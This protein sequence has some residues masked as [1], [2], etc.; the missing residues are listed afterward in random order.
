MAQVV[1]SSAGHCL[2]RKETKHLRER[3]RHS[4]FNSTLSSHVHFLS[5]LLLGMYSLVG[6]CPPLCCSLKTKNGNRRKNPFI[7][8][9]SAIHRPKT[10]EIKA[11]AC[12]RN[13]EGFIDRAASRQAHSRHSNLYAFPFLCFQNILVR[14]EKKNFFFNSRRG[15]SRL[16]GFEWS[17]SHIHI[18]ERNPQVHCPCPHKQGGLEKVG[19]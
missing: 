10:G 15:K 19:C 13:K 5:P 9:Y 14:G 17:E 8:W 18:L 16:N 4:F 3:E 11:P 12:S 2:G 1:R 7:T 6:K